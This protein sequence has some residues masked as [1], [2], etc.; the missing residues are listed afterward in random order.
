MGY[1]RINSA[2]FLGATPQLK[3]L[4][5]VSNPTDR[6]RLV[7]CAMGKVHLEIGIVIRNFDKSGV[8]L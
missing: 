8:E 2:Y 5:M 4:D 7:T 3:N 6:F 1:R